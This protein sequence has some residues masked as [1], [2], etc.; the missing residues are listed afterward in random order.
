MKLIDKYI[1][2][3]LIL[4]FFFGVTAFTSIST[5]VGV[6]P[7]LINQSVKYSLGFETVIKLFFS[8][9]P[10]LIV[11]TFPMSIL[12]ASIIAF[13]RLSS[14]SEVTAFRAGGISF[15]R[16]VVP[17]LVLGFLVSLLTIAFNEFIV[18]KANSYSSIVLQHAKA[19]DKPKIQ[20]SVTIP[21]YS[22]GVLKRN[23]FAG[24]I[25]G[26]IMKD[27]S[28]VEYDKGMFARAIIAKQARWQQNGGWIFEDGVM[29]NFNENQPLSVL[30]ITFDKEFININQTPE[31]ML[32]VKERRTRKN[33]DYIE[34]S[35]YIAQRKRAGLDV[36]G[37]QISLNQK[38]SIPFACFIFSLLGAPMGVKPTRGSSTMGI[39][40]SLL[41]VVIYYIL[42]AIGQWVGTYG[43][44][45][46]WLAAWLPNIATGTVG[47]VL[48]YRK[49]Q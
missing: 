34:L 43:Y 12:L 16:M 6:I 37:H 44:L 42:M 9:M 19:V 18:P 10:E 23:L 5:G 47:A 40:F 41:V 2:G 48:L 29:H 13:N 25:E 33:M 8:R 49:A 30:S 3:E 46:P 4:P 24:S 22:G 11:Y 20:E 7:G 45:A 14:E 38:I 32:I 21:E 26:Q 35:D 27:V 28:V 31:D 17:A 1:A 15:Y 36:V 39:G